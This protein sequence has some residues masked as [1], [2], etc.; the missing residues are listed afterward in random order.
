MK[1]GMSVR[2]SQYRRLWMFAVLLVLSFGGL[3]YRLVDIQILRHEELLAKTVRMRERLQVQP[4]TARSNIRRAWTV[5]GDQCAGQVGVC[6]I[7]G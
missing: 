3:G 4:S 5:A 6:R 7:P 1:S 2:P